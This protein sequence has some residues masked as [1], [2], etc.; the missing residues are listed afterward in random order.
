MVN[1]V[2]IYRVIVAENS[3]RPVDLTRRGWYALASHREEEEEVVDNSL[4]RTESNRPNERSRQ[5]R[6]EGGILDF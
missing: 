6:H 1:K 2:A 5:K 4:A 3:W